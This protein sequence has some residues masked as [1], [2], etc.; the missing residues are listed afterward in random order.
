V[1]FSPEDASRTEVDYLC[2]CYKEAIDAGATTVGFPDT[3][4]LLTPRKAADFIKA[5]QDGVPN[6]DRALLA[7]H[8]HNDL[9]LAVANTLACIEEG[10]NVVQCTV[11]GIGE[12]AGNASLEEVVMALAMHGDQYRR[13]FRIDT[14]KLAPLCQ[15]VAQLTGVMISRM[16][17]IG[18]ANIFAT[19]AGIHQDGLLKNPDTYLPFRPEVVGGGELQLVLGRH[20]GR[21]AVAHRLA[22]LTI[23][24]D[25]QDVLK[26]MELIKQQ[27]KGV[28]IDDHKLRQLVAQI[29]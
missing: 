5:I 7:V 23:T 4:G 3:V 9:G 15:L 16:K 18:G 22:E 1:A 8:F 2:Q 19:E 24:A 10:A 21:K 14:S 29:R 13:K 17:P 20:C 12:R 26:I 11:N 25:D 27:P 28:V 6:L